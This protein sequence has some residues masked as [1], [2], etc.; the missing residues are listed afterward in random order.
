MKRLI[1][2]MLL[3]LLAFNLAA[4]DEP[5]TAPDW[6]LFTTENDVLSLYEATAEQPVIVFFWAT[7]CPYCKALMPEL[8][9]IQDEYGD[10][11]RVLAVHFRDDYGDAVAYMAKNGYDFTLL[12]NGDNVAKLNNIWSTPGVLVV[13]QDRHIR[14]NLYDLAKRNFPDGLSH[15]EKSK[16]L[17][18]Y[19]SA[20]LRKSLQTVVP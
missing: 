10:R 2:L 4:A 11:V 13:D 15:S 17:A 5:R 7:W 1:S 16:Q 6:Q 19:W 9:K 14:F 3:G 20:E 8:Q 12:R 18:P